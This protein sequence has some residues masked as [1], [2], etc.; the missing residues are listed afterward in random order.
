MAK[1]VPPN[2][3]Q[4]VVQ[5]LRCRYTKT[6]RMRFASHRDFQRSLERAIRRADIPIAYSGGFSPRPRISYANAAPTGAA[7]QAEYIELGLRTPVDPKDLTEAVS[8]ALPDGF[9]IVEAI[10]AGGGKLADQL[11]VS[12]WQLELMGTEPEQLSQALAQL[13]GAEPVLFTRVTKSGR[14]EV[15]LSAA[16]LTHTV[17]AGNTAPGQTCAILRVVV[18]HQT[19]A[20]RPD[21]IL[22][23]LVERTDL[24]PPTTALI[25]RL[26]QG[27]LRES[28]GLPGDPLARDK[29]VDEQ[30]FG[31]AAA[32]PP[33]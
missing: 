6:G 21:D 27:P 25:T 16:W 32:D 9:N 20:V 1:R 3:A 2:E 22:S 12:H 17:S 8:K 19:P 18:Q 29:G 7:S 14:K 30:A 24:D 28:S 10:P 11:H 5:R 26:A 23:V 13:L 15:D 31:S 4:P 33:T